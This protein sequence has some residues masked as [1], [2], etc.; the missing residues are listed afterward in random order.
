MNKQEFV[1]IVEGV[2]PVTYTVD[3]NEYEV[4]CD[5]PMCDTLHRR[6]GPD[7][8]VNRVEWVILEDGERKG[9]AGT[10]DPFERKRDALAYLTQYV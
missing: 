5:H 6:Y 3:K 9:W 8:E 4:P 10:T 1:R 7:H 2:G